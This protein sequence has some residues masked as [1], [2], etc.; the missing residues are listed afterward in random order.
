MSRASMPSPWRE[1][2]GSTALLISLFAIAG[3]FATFQP[4][5]PTVT[6]SGGRW[7]GAAAA[8]L[9]YLGACAAL[10]LVRR[11]LASGTAT[12]RQHADSLRVVF[13][14]QTGL[15]EYFAR[16]TV[17]S[18]RSAGV[19]SHAVSIADVDA[20][21]LASASRLLFV[22]STTGEGDA[23][24]MAAGFERHV[25][26][27][28]PDLASLH[29]GVLA[30][31][32]R[33]YVEFC[34]FGRR[35]DSWLRARGATPLF[36]P[37]EVDNGDVGALRRWLHDLRQLS[38]ASELPDW[39]A[40]QY[41]PWRLSAR[42]HLNP[43]SQGEAAFHLE[44]QPARTDELRWEAGDIAEIGPRHAL[45]C[46]AAWLQSNGLDGDA[47]VERGDRRDTLA[48][49]LARSHWPDPVA[50]D[51]DAATLVASLAPLPHRE[52]SIA[53]L[54]DDGAVH[55]LVRQMRRPDGSLGV[56]SA[57]LTE[58]AALGER[59]D[60]R[61]RRNSSFH[62]PHDDRPLLLIGNGTGI[63]GLRA[64][65]K[66]RV[67]RAQHRNWLVFG[68]RE[69]AVD[70]FYTDEL[71][72]WRREGRLERLDLVY[73]RDGQAHRYVQ[74]RLAAQVEA[75]RDWCDRGASIYICGSL[76][77]MASAVEAVIREALGGDAFDALRLAGRYRRD[78]Y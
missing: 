16:R 36:D 73:S 37:V 71:E 62:L 61:L 29:Y 58:H 5:W 21:L 10:L 78:V 9:V 42:Q 64:L 4:S 53:S 55:L 59:V 57:W 24:D 23:P 13:A 27:T 66:A 14:S 31:G 43:G 39:E 76:G 75:I 60:L 22:V 48:A 51:I 20:D 3:L 47:L 46:V 68:E 35:L 18:L 8:T 25:L 41:R 69:A 49:W 30:L 50:P 34:G 6:G 74:H 2:L 17:E 1:R 70:R 63:A 65:L 32:D 28:R 33:E 44:L 19:A 7:L 45:H 11:S 12:T 54:P 38:G 56:G 72:T 52:Y 77:G 15:A 67:A 40:P 26:G